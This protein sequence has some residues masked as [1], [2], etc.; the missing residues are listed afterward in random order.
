MNC[1][2]CDKPAVVHELV[3]KNGAT[4]EVHLCEEHA[5][6]HGYAVPAHQPVAHLLTPFAVVGAGAKV[7]GALGKGKIAKVIKCCPECGLTFAH[8]RQSGLLGCSACYKAFDAE[9]SGLIERAQAGANFHCG[10]APRDCRNAAA[11]LELR[12]RLARELDE[13]VAAEQYERAAKVR[14]QLLHLSSEVIAD[15][16]PGTRTGCPTDRA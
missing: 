4:V 7:P 16:E 6:A 9:L 14:D 1:D 3:I 11:R 5:A 10:K 2:H 12:S 8:V 13:A 15:A